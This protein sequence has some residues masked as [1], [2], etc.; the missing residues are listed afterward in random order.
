MKEEWQQYAE[1]DKMR[2]D[3][4]KKAATRCIDRETDDAVDLDVDKSTDM[5]DNIKVVAESSRSLSFHDRTRR[6][7]PHRRPLK[8]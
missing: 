5:E 3:V 1:Y 4:L 6:L 2:A 8:E 7:L